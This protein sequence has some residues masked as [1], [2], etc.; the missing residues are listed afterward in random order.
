MA[1]TRIKSNTAIAFIQ[2]ELNSVVD[3]VMD[4]GI[5]WIVVGKRVYLENGGIY[6]VIGQTGF[7]YQLQL[8]TATTLPGQIVEVGVMY[9]IENSDSSTMWGGENGKIW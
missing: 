7:V 3:V 1:I 2:P 8:K 4:A 9:P 6:Q 5:D